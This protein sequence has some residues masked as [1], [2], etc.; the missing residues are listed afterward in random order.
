[1][2][3][4]LQNVIGIVVLVAYGAFA[5]FMLG[6]M[7]DDAPT[8]E[9][10]A[11]SFVPPK[12]TDD[13]YF[14]MTFVALKRPRFY[15]DPKACEFDVQ[16]WEAAPYS[17]I[18]ENVFPNVH[19]KWEAVARSVGHSPDEP[20]PLHAPVHIKVPV[21]IKHYAVFMNR[22][23]RAEAGTPAYAIPPKPR[24]ETLDVTASGRCGGQYG[25]GI[26]P[27]FRDF[28]YSP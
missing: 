5:A 17:E 27:T 22:G 19:V 24:S 10:K 14:E 12:G 16:W 4:R 15:Q 28:P 3:A 8:I 2:N 1:M 26:S 25:R 21:D 23:K 20:P 9:V 18:G 7:G 11:L 13:A 6:V